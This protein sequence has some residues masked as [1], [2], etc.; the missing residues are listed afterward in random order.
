MYESISKN[1]ELEN[2]MTLDMSYFWY[3]DIS[4]SSSP[5]IWYL[6]HATTVVLPLQTLGYN[7]AYSTSPCLA[8]LY[9]CKLVIYSADHL[10]V[11]TN[12]PKSPPWQS[13]AALTLSCIKNCFSC[14]MV[15]KPTV[16]LALLNS[17]MTQAISLNASSVN[18]SM[19]IRQSLWP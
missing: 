18:F 16:T 7:M 4:I 13:S 14:S 8:C 6:H 1:N 9:Y 19:Q 11:I 5:G 12:V 15:T 10:H 3:S 17:N 2:E